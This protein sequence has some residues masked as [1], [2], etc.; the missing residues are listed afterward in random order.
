MYN[1]IIVDDELIIR[2]GLKAVIAWEDYGFTIIGEAANG[3][4]GKEAVLEKKPDLILVDIRMPGIDGIELLQQVRKEGYQGRVIILTGYAEFEYAKEAI[5]LDVD[6]YLLKPIDEDELGNILETMKEQLDISHDMMLKQEEH[7]DL[8]LERN[9]MNLILDKGQ[10][11]E[12]K[13]MGFITKTDNYYVVVIDKYRDEYLKYE[14]ILHEMLIQQ[15]SCSLLYFEEY[16]VVIFK[17][18]TYRQIQVVLEEYQKKHLRECGFNSYIAVGRSVKDYKKLSRS[19]EDA[20]SL[21]EKKFLY[22]GQDLVFWDG[23]EEVPKSRVRDLDTGY[24]YNLIEVGNLDA[25]DVYFEQLENTLI[26]S[27]LQVDKIKGICI[28]CFIEVKEK[29]VNQYSKCSKEFPSNTALIDKIY[30]YQK[31]NDITSYMKDTFSNASE[32]ICD[33]SPEN[34]MKRLL[35]YI[36]INYFK[37]LKLEGLA[38]LFNYNSSYL[39]KIFKERTGENFNNYLDKIRIEHAKEL[40]D[41]HDYKV[42]E[43]AEKVGYKSVDYFY[44]KFKKHVGVSPKCYKGKVD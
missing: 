21:F 1:V 41:S 19:Y 35:N 30:D 32:T 10:N 12:L 17:N 22:R 27:N 25:I 24:L 13:D 20:K 18:K 3:I 15:N 2:E 4:S 8:K 16:Y 42:Y 9:L 5:R 34:T 44:T 26:Q 43:V 6:A 38:K 11:V 31:L 33:G 40:L 37:S 7:N 29:V 14:S 28:N 39:G 23:Y 36:H